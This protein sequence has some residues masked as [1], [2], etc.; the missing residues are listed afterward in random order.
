MS[1]TGPSVSQKKKLETDPAKF[2]LHLGYYMHTNAWI[3]SSDCTLYTQD[4]G[5]AESL[6]DM[7]RQFEELFLRPSP[8]FFYSQVR[9]R[10]NMALRVHWSFINPIRARRFPPSGPCRMGGCGKVSSSTA[11]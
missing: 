7:Q 9:A 4:N 10:D 1:K 8:P 3:S 6:E 11:G 2:I 5:K